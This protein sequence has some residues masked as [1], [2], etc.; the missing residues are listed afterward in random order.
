VNGP[1]VEVRNIYLVESEMDAR[2]Q[3]SI[4][5]NKKLRSTHLQFLGVHT[6]AL[7]CPIYVFD[8]NFGRA[9]A[10][11]KRMYRTAWYIKIWIYLD[12]VN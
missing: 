6:H 7:P 10:I 9:E 5:E 1:K 2:I 12:M 3:K 4:E 8:T 11:L